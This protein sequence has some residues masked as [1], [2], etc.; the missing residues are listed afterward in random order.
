MPT[1]PIKKYSAL[2]SAMHNRRTA[3]HMWANAE[4]KH[5]TMPL[6]NQNVANKLGLKTTDKV[7]YFASFSGEWAKAIANDVQQ[8]DASDI[9]N[10][11]ADKLK[12]DKDKINRVSEL[13]A[14][15]HNPLPEY[16]DWS[17]SFEPIPLLYS[18][19]LEPTIRAGL[20]NKKG[21][22]L[23]FS[24]VVFDNINRLFQKRII[25][26]SRIYKFNVK[27]DIT[28][29][30]TNRLN[31]EPIEL[32]TITTNDVARK[33]AELDI[34]VERLRSRLPT[35]NNTINYMAKILNVPRYQILLSLKRLELIDKIR[36]E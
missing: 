33:Q 21:I 36:D 11:W 6:K 13:P 8:L 17:V 35:N 15:I 9:T 7:H 12:K 2:I 3:N 19:G 29:I 28:E 34:S 22:K 25:A 20:L 26:L 24:S 5:S 16:Y 14:E 1:Q 27:I 4:K 23:I 32:V 31:Q 30:D 10:F 18:G